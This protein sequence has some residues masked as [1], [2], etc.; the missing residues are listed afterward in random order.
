MAN[1]K[2][3]TD[4]LYTVNFYGAGKVE[5]VS[6]WAHSISY[7]HEMY[8]FVNAEG[9]TVFEIPQEA[10]ICMQQKDAIENEQ[11]KTGRT[12]VLAGRQKSDPT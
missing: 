2:P 3:K 5:E 11:R 9:D 6:I 4:R 7:L 10:L 12:L 1:R 8:A